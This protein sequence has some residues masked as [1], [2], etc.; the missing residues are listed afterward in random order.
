MSA[1]KWDMSVHNAVAAI[2]RAAQTAINVVDSLADE[3][4]R[5]LGTAA[6]D[7]TYDIFEELEDI[8]ADADALQ[9]KVGQV[10]MA[11]RNYKSP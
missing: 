1:S 10:A 8:Y 11:L 6:S 4:G 2:V 5:E 7:L 9:R 3:V